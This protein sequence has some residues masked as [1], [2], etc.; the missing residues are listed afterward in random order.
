[1]KIFFVFFVV[2]FTFSACSEDPTIGNNNTVYRPPSKTTPT[3]NL[4]PN[5]TSTASN[6][7]SSQST[8]GMTDHGMNYGKDC[9]DVVCDAK[10]RCVRGKC[11]SVSRKIACFNM[12][13]MGTI[14]IQNPIRVEGDTQGYADS[15]L[16]SCTQPENNFSG[17]ENAIHFKVSANAGVKIKLTS[18]AAIDWVMDIRTNCHEDS[19]SLLCSDPETL[20]F[21]AKAGTDYYIIV[22]PLHG[23]DRGAFKL[24][25]EFIPLHCAPPGSRTCMA[26]NIAR[27]IRGGQEIEILKCA[28]GC[29]QG[30]CTGDS[31]ASPII[32]NGPHSYSGDSNAFNSTMDFGTRATCSE[33]GTHGIATPGSEIVLWVPNLTAG[34]HLLIDTSMNDKNDNAIFIL[35]NCTLTE[36]CLAAI[37][38]GEKLDWTVPADGGYFVIIDKVSVNP[39][40]FQYSIDIQ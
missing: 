38:L 23:I 2:L 18:T 32:V 17:S 15:L 34:Q 24:D 33:D 27:C 9:K 31:C 11:A 35:K 3:N 19:S 10:Q 1:M 12:I 13:E 30:V 20:N 29:D 14:D 21:S 40:P 39:H 22:E 28:S 7:Q 26:G 37:D 36:K 4:K 25:F 16:A 6:N 5:G 8:V